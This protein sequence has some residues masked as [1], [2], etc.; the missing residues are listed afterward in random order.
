M[1]ERTHLKVKTLSGDAVLL[2]FKNEDRVEI[3]VGELIVWGGSV[4]D[5]SYAIS[6][7]RAFTQFNF[8]A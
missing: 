8:A 2:I 7:P 4:G 1:N 5:W 6:H 3:R